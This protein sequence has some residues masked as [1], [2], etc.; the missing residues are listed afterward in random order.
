MEACAYHE[1][2][3]AVGTCV[4]CGQAVC[5]KCLDA[6][7]RG[8][9]GM[10]AEVHQAMA[11]APA[12][13]TAEA[14][15][16]PRPPATEG[17]KPSRAPAPSR[18]PGG[19]GEGA[20]AKAGAG[21]R[22]PKHPDRPATVACA[23]C[24]AKHCGDCINLYDLCPSC[25][26]LPTCTRHE[27]LVAES[28]CS[29]CKAPYCADCLGTTQTCPGCRESAKL[30]AGAKPS[31]AAPAKEEAPAGKSTGG[32]PK[33]ATGPLKGG[34]GPATGK[35]SPGVRPKGG[36]SKGGTGRLPATKVPPTAPPQQLWLGLGAV[37]LSVALLVWIMATGGK[38]SLSDQ[39]ATVAL[40]DEMAKVQR[41]A[42]D[43]H[44]R[45]GEYP[46]NSQALI[47]E[48]EAQG[49]KVKE[50]PLPLKLVV[51]VPP[52]EPWSIG[53]TQSGTGFEIRAVD[54][55]GRPFSIDGRDV[56]MRPSLQLEGPK[57]APGPEGS[58]ANGGQGAGSG[59]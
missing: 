19:P 27:S 44:K 18:S 33:S 7:A 40:R 3:E 29:S 14:N 25:A 32:A 2:D 28:R 11:A 43:Y 48:L 38:P 52:S 16:R 59:P 20:K 42:M 56:I 39:E 23:H 49:V 37:A 1:V 22:C 12:G 26:A 17:A 45:N 21:G 8:M 47:S 50:L 54:G 55:L 30:R 41:A 10:C 57:E 46:N 9:C 15:A 24:Q 13:P 34:A 6:G 36:P 35:L 53:Y 5:A 4:S 31:K 51:N 58:G